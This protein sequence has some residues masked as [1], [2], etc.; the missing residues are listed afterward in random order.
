MN[1]IKP[2]EGLRLAKAFYEKNPEFQARKPALIKIAGA[3]GMTTYWI[4]APL[5]GSFARIYIPS[6][7]GDEGKPQIVLCPSIRGQE[8][9]ARFLVAKAI[10]LKLSGFTGVK[11]EDSQSCNSSNADEDFLNSV[12]VGLLM[13]PGLVAHTLPLAK[14]FTSLVEFFQT[15]SMV[16]EKFMY[17][18]LESAVAKAYVDEKI[19][20]HTGPKV[21]LT[22]NSAKQESKEIDYLGEAVS[23]GVGIA[24]GSLLGF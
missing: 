9:R 14:S 12:A 8:H 7:L 17:S 3:L 11:L 13:P 22:R 5:K 16:A 1:L 20:F 23:A 15:T 19:T 10:A 6:D 18:C 4:D 21:S 2:N 24:I